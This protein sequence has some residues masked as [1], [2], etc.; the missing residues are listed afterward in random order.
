MKPLRSM[1]IVGLISGSAFSASGR[2]NTYSAAVDTSSVTGTPGSLDFNFNPGGLTAQAA[3][4][5]TLTRW[6]W[7]LSSVLRR[8]LTC[9]GYV[10]TSALM[11]AV[12][13]FERHSLVTAPTP[14]VSK[15]DRSLDRKRG[16]R[17]L[18]VDT[19]SPGDGKAVGC[20][21]PS[22]SP[23]AY[24]RTTSYSGRSGQHR[25]HGPMTA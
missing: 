8:L 16:H 13:Q 5:E 20:V 7:R 18:W 1:L 24:D 19:A 15:V 4:V 25:P 22:G 2:A 3:S 10:Q 12:Q 17:R 21:L 14:S 6:Q 23:E 11:A 9:A